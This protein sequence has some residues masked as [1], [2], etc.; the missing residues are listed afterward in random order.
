M[1]RNGCRLRKAEVNREIFS[2]SCRMTE[3]EHQLQ[4]L[5]NHAHSVSKRQSA[6]PQIRASKKPNLAATGDAHRS[7]FQ[8][9]PTEWLCL[10]NRALPITEIDL[11]EIIPGRGLHIRT[12][13]ESWLVSLPEELQSA[14][15]PPRGER[16]FSA[17]PAEARVRIHPEASAGVVGILAAVKSLVA[18]RREKTLR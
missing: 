5:K 12:R 10:E 11:L 7:V 18:A 15:P 3:I 8:R 4:H 13:Q 6:R 9:K 16:S 17:T 1:T 2:A 14:P